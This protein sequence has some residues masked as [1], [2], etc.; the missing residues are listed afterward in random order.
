MKTS[1]EQLIKEI[2]GELAAYLKGGKLNP[3][4][5]IRQLN[6]NIENLAQLLQ[7][8]FMME[9]EVQDFIRLLGDRLR[10][11]KTST[12]TRNEIFFGEI[13]GSIDWQKTINERYKRNYR[14][15]TIFSCNEKNRSY[16][17][18]ENLVLK[19]FIEVLYKIF[20]VYIDFSRLE[21]Y[22]WLKEGSYLK[23]IVKEVYEKN[24]YLSKIKTEK[25]KVTDRMIEDTLKNRNHLYSESAKLLKLYR[26]LI[27]FHLDEEEVYKL[28]ADTFIYADRDETLFELYWVTKLIRDNAENHRLFLMDGNSSMVA[29]WEKDE[30]IYEIYHDS[31]GGFDTVFQISLNE[32]ETADNPFIKRKLQA[33]NKTSE[34]TALLL[35]DDEG[36][37][38]KYL[39]R[40]RPDII[41]NIRDKETKRLKRLI[42]GE[43]KYTLSREYAL[44]GLK[45]LIEY[46]MFVKDNRGTYLYDNSQNVNIQGVLFLDDISF[47]KIEDETIKVVAIKDNAKL[48]I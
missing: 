30:E 48:L 35:G 31:A 29:S 9:E 19:E 33:I 41:V 43:V 22:E 13:K 36:N 1:R 16:D 17:I 39:W 47:N 5:F 18:K 44:E 6:L 38:N 40:G 34:L 23:N 20:F 7:I 10:R 24:I 25:S 26:N 2:G 42:L 12:V 15:N 3:S 8:H 32:I 45:E 37:R 11:V 21:N 27:N 14:D 46:V 28:F 4:P